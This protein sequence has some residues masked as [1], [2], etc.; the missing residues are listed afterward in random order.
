MSAVSPSPR[1]LEV[2]SWWQPPIMLA[3]APR[4]DILGGPKEPDADIWDAT[5][6][7]YVHEIRR[8]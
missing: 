2:H 6:K 3:T 8:F 1:N 4:P 5:S 7:G